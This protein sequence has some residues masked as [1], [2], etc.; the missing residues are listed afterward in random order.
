MIVN[1]FVSQVLLLVATTSLITVFASDS[2]TK[3]TRSRLAF[4]KVGQAVA[5]P[6]AQGQESRLPLGRG[7]LPPPQSQ[8]VRR[9]AVHEDTAPAAYHYHH[10]PASFH[11]DA[12][13][14]A[15]YHHWDGD[16]GHHSH[17]DHYV[18]NEI[19]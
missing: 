19:G 1:G 16:E 13:V 4:P 18:S 17:H 6:T 2:P 5:Q 12:D 14:A 11:Q 3:G 10:D 8:P 9:Y 7:V 15:A